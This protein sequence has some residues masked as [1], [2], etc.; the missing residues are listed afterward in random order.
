MSYP[1][2]I[3][4][5]QLDEVYYQ[6]TDDVGSRHFIG[7]LDDALDVYNAWSEMKEPDHFELEYFVE[8][9]GVEFECDFDLDIEDED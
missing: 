9:D 5:E 2:F 8:L 4:F 6:V 3:E 1:T 7:E